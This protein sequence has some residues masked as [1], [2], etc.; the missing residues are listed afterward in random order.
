ME[1]NKKNGTLAVSGTTLDGENVVVRVWHDNELKNCESNVTKKIKRVKVKKINIKK[2]EPVWDIAVRDNRN[3]FA[4]KLL[5]HNCFEIGFIPVTKDGRCGYH[6]C[7][8]TT[9]NGAKISSLE[10]W[11]AAAKA[12][13]IIGTLQASYTHFDYLSSASKELTEEEALLGVSMTG[14]FDNPSLLLN[15]ENQ[16][17]ISKLCVKINKEWSEI[18]GINQAARV[19]C[20]K[21]EGSSSLVLESSSGIHP[22]HSHRYFRRVQMNK[23]DPIYKFFKKHNPHMCEESVWSASKTDDVV[24]FPLTIN[25]EAITKKDLTAI[26]HLTYIK[27][28]Q[29]NWVRSGTTEV[30]KKPVEHNV[31]CTVEVDKNE[32]SDVIKFIYENR[33]YF[34]AVSLLSK[35]GDRDYQQAPLQRITDEDEEKWKYIIDNYKAPNYNELIEE[36]DKTSAMD[37]VACGGGV[38]EIF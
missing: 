17:M 18:I 13:T 23:T 14:W 19:T 29:I 8:L 20:T 4:N 2:N 37:T 10:E 24:T 34:T 25:K 21:P 28:T 9:Q 1:I 11:K 30:N 26:Q 31:S 32:W 6:F 3:F 15:E 5:V 35:S 22:H 7:N 12:A 33:Q 38:C 27:S 16:Y 36:D